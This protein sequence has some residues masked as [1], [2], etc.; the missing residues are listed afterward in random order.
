M[1]RRNFVKGLAAYGLLGCSAAFAV[2]NVQLNQRIVNIA[3]GRIGKPGGDRYNSW[4]FAYN[5]LMAA[6]AKGPYYGPQ[7]Q[8]AWGR[9]ITFREAKAGDIIQI[10][11]PCAFRDC[12]NNRIYWS[13]GGRCTW[14]VLNRMNGRRPGSVIDVAYM[15][16][17]NLVRFARIETCDICTNSEIYFYRPQI[18]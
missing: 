15:Y 10:E 18:K 4:I 1:K 8:Y 2:D 17:E 9:P 12:R 7:N 5:T 11:N 14:V 6:G 16:K 3:R 13:C